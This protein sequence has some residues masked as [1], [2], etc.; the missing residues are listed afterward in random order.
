MKTTNKT[1]ISL[2]IEECY[3]NGMRKVVCSPGSRNAP[4]VIALD[5]FSGIET[6]VIHDER[7][8]GFFAM[9]MAQE[10]N[11]PV[12][13]VCTSGSAVLNYFPAV[14]EAFYQQIPLVIISADRPKEW[15]NHGVGQ[16]IMQENVF[17][18]HVR[19]FEEI[20]EFINNDEEK[21]ELKNKVRNAFAKAVETW[22]GPVHF[23]VPVSEPLYEIID[24]DD[25]LPIGVQK[26][27]GE[28]FVFSAKEKKDI[29]EKWASFPR[30]M[31][32]CGQMEKNGAIQT[33][34][35][36]FASDSAV[37]VMVENTSNL[38]GNRFVH[39]IDRTLQAIREE[40]VSDYNPD[41][42]IT[43]GGAIVSKKI[44]DFLRKANI[45]EHW[46]IGFDFPK[47]DT[48]RHLT[49]H[50]NCSSLSF[51]KQLQI[52]K[53]PFHESSFGNKWKQ[54]DVLTKDKLM[55]FPYKYPFSDLKVVET[56]LDFLPENVTLHMGNSSV[57]RYCQLF[58]PIASVTYFSNRGTSGIDGCTSTASGVAFMQKERL[59]VLITGDV[60]FFYDSNA[61]WNE[62][63]T[64]NLCIII[65]NNQGGGIFK[66]ID[67]PQKTNQLEKFFVAEHTLHA[68][69]LAKTYGCSYLSIDNQVKLE[70]SLPNFY[71][72][73]KDK[74]VI[75]EVFTNSE[76][77][78]KEL[79][80]Y[81]E[82][83]DNDRNS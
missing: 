63:L 35:D 53:L 52:L 6:L 71:A 73:S 42:L 16:T 72:G 83:I 76:W 36:Y 43:I 58:D 25:S 11:Q 18:N 77:N 56:I 10:S 79:K 7:S 46:R 48:Y 65:I 78:D 68:E 23:N 75:M 12:G 81:F 8:A 37:V 19:Y 2:F 22:K 32:L 20:P 30:K 28:H 57:V 17:G 40:E 27:K 4:L 21:D 74:P 62:N 67:G 61:L 66:I 50:F 39:C 9:G 31:I 47:M 59:N 34:L 69:Q 54:L 82:F 33:I 55:N 60:S 13:V 41:L 14:A 49:K 70:A 29:E 5:E 3:R 45:K 51:L 80:R 64:G 24:V 38:K 44:K 26:V 1:G 15:I